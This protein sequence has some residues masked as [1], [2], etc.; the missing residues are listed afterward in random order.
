MP[1]TMQKYDIYHVILKNNVK[2][3][4]ND[5][6]SSLSVTFYGAIPIFLLH[7]IRYKHAEVQY[8]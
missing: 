7:I 3:T 2:N 1:N 6:K 8:F 5:T 4:T